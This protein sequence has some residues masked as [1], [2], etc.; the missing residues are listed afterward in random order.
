MPLRMLRARELPAA[1]R[2]GRVPRE[3][4]LRSVRRILATCLRYYAERDEAEPAPGVVAGPEHR[5]LARKVAV[6]SVLL[7][8]EAVDG[9][10]MLPL[11]VR[12]DAWR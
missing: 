12:S 6:G 10:P 4:V 3:T 1:L 8:N 5:A 9:K 7:K 11:P 2:D